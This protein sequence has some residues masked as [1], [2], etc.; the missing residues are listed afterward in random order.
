MPVAVYHHYKANILNIRHRKQHSGKV[1]RQQAIVRGPSKRSTAIIF[2]V[3][4]RTQCDPQHP[5]D[6]RKSWSDKR[7]TD[8]LYCL[9]GNSWAGGT[10][11]CCARV[12]EPFGSFQLWKERIERLEEKYKWT[13]KVKIYHKIELLMD[14]WM[15]TPFFY[16]AGIVA[17]ISFFWQ[18]FAILPEWHLKQC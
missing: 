14:Q 7:V 4:C 11:D 3:N 18:L 12:P 9:Q 15:S 17:Y 10:S 6:G 5:A 2:L 13:I 1:C 8:E 16:W